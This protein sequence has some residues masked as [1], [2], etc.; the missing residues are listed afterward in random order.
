MSVLIKEYLSMQETI[1]F[2]FERTGEK[3][4]YSTLE[5][6]SNVNQLI[7][8]FLFSGHVGCRVD[9]VIV[10]EKMKAYFTHDDFFM[11]KTRN[12]QSYSM[13][14]DCDVPEWIEIDTPFTIRRILKQQ[15][16]IH[17]V[18]DEV[19]L[20][21]QTPTPEIGKLDAI[22]LSTI[23]FDD[24]R[25]SRN[26]LSFLFADKRNE[27]NDTLS[28]LNYDGEIERADTYA[29]VI[30][31]ETEASQLMLAQEKIAELEQQLS[32]F[33]AAAPDVV[34]IPFG[35]RIDLINKDLSQD[36]RIKQSYE[37]YSDNMSF[38]EDM[39]PVN[40]PD[41]MIKRIQGLLKVIK[42]K[43]SKIL[44]LEKQTN[45]PAHAQAEIDELKEQL[46]K[47]N[48]ELV[49]VKTATTAQPFDWQNMSEYIYPPELHLAM[50][51]WQRI[52]AD[53]ELKESH[54]HI[55]SH[56]G[57]FELIAKRMNLDP[58]IGLGKRIE[59]ITN[60]AFTKKGQTLLAVPLQNV[61]ELHMPPLKETTTP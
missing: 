2:V 43:D 57:K 16:T 42:R 48:A 24:V 9:G 61:K 53:E 45:A 23:D 35:K 3:I 59:V 56:A 41:E 15:M 5:E 12:S 32:K 8:V 30:K 52:Y 33:Q 11:H 7:P 4:D 44:E 17:K 26:E 51:I 25:F 58:T 22:K 60:T 46:N 36:E 1:D 55:S 28:Q 20:F 21:T 27:I 18:F 40:T 10:Y 19:F 6:L 49:A 31:I 13:Y 47:A 50:M 54:P 38:H 34:R 39:H 14:G 37:I 29:D